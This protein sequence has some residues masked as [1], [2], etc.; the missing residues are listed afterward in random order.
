M[1]YELQLQVLQGDTSKIP[2]MIEGSVVLTNENETYV[3]FN[4]AV[5]YITG[6]TVSIC[7]D[8]I[9]DL[10][11][12]LISLHLREFKFKVLNFKSGGCEDV[13]AFEEEWE[14]ED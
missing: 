14:E 10:Y 12:T 13:V 11:V 9:D 2:S 7:A 3:I 5:I 1:P 4:N 8:N 6:S